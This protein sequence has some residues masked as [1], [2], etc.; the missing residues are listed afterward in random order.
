[1]NFGLLDES[2]FSFDPF[3]SRPSCPTQTSSHFKPQQL[4]S[5]YIAMDGFTLELAESPV[6]C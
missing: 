2:P 6:R 1:M 5:P 3:T 4:L